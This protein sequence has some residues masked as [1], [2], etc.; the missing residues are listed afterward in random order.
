MIKSLRK[1]HF[2]LWLFLM[3]SIPAGII[4][5]WLAVPNREPIRLLNE[6]R[7]SRLP[8]VRKVYDRPSFSA[9]VLTNDAQTS[10]QLEWNNK[11]TLMVPSAVIY[12][13]TSGR[14]D[15]SNAQLVGRIEAR[16]RYWFPLD[17]PA[18]T[19]GELHLVLYDFIH[20]QILEHINIRL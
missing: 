15:L 17:S 8:M 19:G 9:S 20:Q 11:E 2:Q 5:V 6:P 14:Q 18:T 10:W 7:E 1:R 3:V 12:R 13:V 4:F 16:G